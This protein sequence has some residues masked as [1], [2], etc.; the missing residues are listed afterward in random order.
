[1]IADSTVIVN[2]TI[3][4]P[5]NDGVTMLSILCITLFKISYNSSALCAKP[6]IILKITMKLQNSIGVIQNT[7]SQFIKPFYQSV[8]I[9]CLKICLQNAS[10]MLEL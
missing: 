3:P 6:C 2:H 7:S 4:I 9:E 1:M 5:S 10:I 8:L